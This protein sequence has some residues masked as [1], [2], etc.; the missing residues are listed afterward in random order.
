MTATTDDCKKFIAS[1]AEARGLPKGGSWKRLSKR[2]GEGGMV[3]REFEHGSGALVLVVEDPKLGAAGLYFGAASPAPELPDFDA[4]GD[5]MK[6]AWTWRD[7][8]RALGGK[9]P[10][11]APSP[12]PHWSW[13]DFAAAGADY[14]GGEVR[15]PY[16]EGGR[17]MVRQLVQAW[18]DVAVRDGAA[19]AVVAQGSAWCF[20]GDF[21][22][23]ERQGCWSPGEP[24]LVYVWAADMPLGEMEDLGSIGYAL[25]WDNSME[26]VFEVG[27]GAASGAEAM[28]RAWDEMKAA[29]LSF[30]AKTQKEVEEEEEEE[31]EGFDEACPLSKK[32]SLVIPELRAQAEKKRLER[33]AGKGKTDTGA[34]SKSL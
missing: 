22:Y 9:K 28:A 26:C 21:D 1:H 10:R 14:G 8:M 27:A 29:G 34:K 16:G 30:D 7:A 13:K 18:L 6:A 24:A 31:E 15:H 4:M 33:S 23:L 5:A 19:R 11:V 20:H 3:E 2:T 25:E 12:D 32:V 17:G